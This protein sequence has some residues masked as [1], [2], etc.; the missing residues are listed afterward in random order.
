[1]KLLRHNEITLKE[2]ESYTSKGEDCCVVNPCGSGKSSV[3]SEFIKEHS[4]KTFV[5]VTKQRN[6]KDYYNGLDNIFSN[7]KIKTYSMMLS[8]YKHKRYC[9]YN[10]DFFIADEAHYLGATKWNEA[11]TFLKD[12]YRPIV[13][14]FTATPQRFADQGTDNTIVT[15]QFNGNSAGNF[16]SK[17]LQN[18]GVFIEPEY[19]LSIYNMMSYIDERITKVENSELTD[20]LKNQYIRKLTDTYDNWYRTSRPE[21]VIENHL[22]D[23]LYKVH[24]NRI[25]VYTPNYSD[26]EQLRVKIDNLIKSKFPSMS[27]KS[28][29]YTYKDNEKEL[30]DFLVED[31]TYIKVLYSI[32]KIMET[33]HIDDLNIVIMLRPSVS[34]R[35]IAQQFGRVNSIGNKHKSLI[36][37]M[38]GNL[39]NI[40]TVNGTE[41]EYKG[42]HEKIRRLTTSNHINVSYVDKYMN[43]FNVIDRIVSKS[44]MYKY[45][46]FVGTLNQICKVYNKDYEETKKLILEDGLDIEDALDKAYNFGSTTINQEIF[47][48]YVNYDNFKLN[49]WQRNFANDNIDIVENFIANKCIKNEDLKQELYMAYL[50]IISTHNSEERRYSIRAD[51][52]NKFNRTYIKIER[53]KVAREK[54]YDDINKTRELSYTMDYIAEA[55]NLKDIL[56]REMKKGLKER[57]YKI[58]CHRFGLIDGHPKTLEEVGKMYNLCRDRIRQIE[59]KALRKLRHTTIARKIVAFAESFNNIT[60]ID[61]ELYSRIGE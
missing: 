42:T 45:K 59:A 48:G 2:L 14:G 52:I 57:E 31:N 34:N 4:D 36:I 49:D 54:L 30:K 61:V 10:T 22:T 56:Y 20:K 35:I 58:I 7:I 33:I 18:E 5:I 27:V 28:Y 41:V 44:K 16:S 3:M 24:C 43:I 51:I 15:K 12:K 11:F 21:L 60:D 39:S 9:D 19:I 23:Y 29:Q 6:A 38:V 46:G 37:D 8:D 1:M 32:D 55:H 53:Q 25:L 17:E 47:D 50:N 26:L 13:I 40:N